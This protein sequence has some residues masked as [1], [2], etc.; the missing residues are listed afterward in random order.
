MILGTQGYRNTRK[1]GGSRRLT[2]AIELEVTRN[3]GGLVLRWGTCSGITHVSSHTQSSTLQS[4]T[5]DHTNLVSRSIYY[6]LLVPYATVDFRPS[7]F[8][9][10]KAVW[11]TVPEAVRFSN[12][13]SVPLKGKVDHDPYRSRINHTAAHY[14]LA[15]REGRFRLRVIAAAH[16]RLVK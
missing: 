14:T 9:R 2:A 11:G 12:I 3:S 15:P 8:T 1:E 6:T 10:S 5:F 7:C 4:A 16:C 13:V